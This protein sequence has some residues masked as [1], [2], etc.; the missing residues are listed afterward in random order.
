[1]DAVS[2][3]FRPRMTPRSALAEA[4]S[5]SIARLWCRKPGGVVSGSWVIDV[6]LGRDAQ[7]VARRSRGYVRTMTLESSDSFLSLFS[8]PLVFVVL[9]DQAAGVWLKRTPSLIIL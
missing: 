3:R 7:M 4:I 1:M 8:I 5:G 2:G 6:R 9:F